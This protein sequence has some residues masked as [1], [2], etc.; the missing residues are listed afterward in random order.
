PFTDWTIKCNR[1]ELSS[2]YLSIRGRWKVESGTESG[3]LI[4]V[5]GYGPTPPAGGRFRQKNG[6]SST[7]HHYCTHQ[8]NE[9]P[10]TYP[11]ASHPHI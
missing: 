8:E 2:S 10:H 9:N 3:V 7:L 1:N 4:A 6:G 5:T 11:A